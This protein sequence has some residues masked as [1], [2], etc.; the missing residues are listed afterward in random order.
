MTELSVAGPFRES[1]FRHQFRLHPM[2]AF[3][4]R[5]ITRKRIRPHLEVRQLLKAQVDQLA[6]RGAA[7]G[8]WRMLPGIQTLGTGLS[9]RKRRRAAEHGE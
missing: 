3:G 6:G 2:N 8:E 4:R 7:E 1:D 5:A 9:E